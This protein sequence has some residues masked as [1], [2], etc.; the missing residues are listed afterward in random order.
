MFQ[1]NSKFL[2]FLYTRFFFSII[3]FQ[4]Y[5]KKMMCNGNDLV[6]LRCTYYQAENQSTRKKV[7][8]FK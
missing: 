2:G 1:Q 6:Y 7:P 3:L 8:I 4:I 5:N